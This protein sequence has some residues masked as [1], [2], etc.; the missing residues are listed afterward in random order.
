MNIIRTRNIFTIVLA[1]A[2]ILSPLSALAATVEQYMLFDIGA[3]GTR[4]ETLYGPGVGVSTT[5][6]LPYTSDT[7]DAFTLSI[8]SVNTSGS[9]SGGI[10]GA[11]GATRPT[12]ISRL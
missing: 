3:G 4:V 2:I 12:A 9:N 7:G 5:S 6:V 10:A 8:D 11:T 1:V